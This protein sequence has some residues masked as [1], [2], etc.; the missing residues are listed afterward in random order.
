MTAVDF[1]EK[2]KRRTHPCDVGYYDNAIT[3]IRVIEQIKEHIGECDMS[4]KNPEDWTDFEKKVIG[5][6]HIYDTSVML[7]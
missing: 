3:A 4:N 5:A 1:L 7:K 2:K 6:I